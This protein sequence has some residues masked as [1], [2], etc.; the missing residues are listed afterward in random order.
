V[1]T[2]RYELGLQIRQMQFRHCRVNVLVLKG[3]V[4]RSISL[5]LQI[6]GFE[7]AGGTSFSIL[8]V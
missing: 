4:T 2:A 3:T 6:V 1:F 7:P 5:L 8:Q